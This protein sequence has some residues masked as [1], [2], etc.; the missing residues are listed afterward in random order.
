MQKCFRC[1]LMF[2]PYSSKQTVCSECIREL[3]HMQPSAG[4]DNV[5]HP[6]HYCKPGVIESIDYI[7][8]T[9]TLDEFIGFCL[10]NVKKYTYRWR[11]KAGLED[12]KKAAW[13]LDRAI[14]KLEATK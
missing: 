4:V 3:E 6:N 12:L 11:D 8:Q 2:E 5:N 7:D 13:Y 9:S 10:G 14:K 1:A